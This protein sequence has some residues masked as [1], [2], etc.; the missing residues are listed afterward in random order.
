M[1]GI[2]A[3][4]I[5]ACSAEAGPGFSCKES[6]ASPDR[7]DKA[8]PTRPMTPCCYSRDRFYALKMLQDSLMCRAPESPSRQAEVWLGAAT[9]RV[10]CRKIEAECLIDLA[11]LP[12]HQRALQRPPSRSFENRISTPA[13]IQSHAHLNIYGGLSRAPGWNAAFSSSSR[14]PG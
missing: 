8:Y 4:S 6:Y 10:S 3:W 2:F 14:R 12:A 7:I 9:W 13:K 1:C 11:T 5:R